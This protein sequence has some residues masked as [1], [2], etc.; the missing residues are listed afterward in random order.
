MGIAG[1]L[2]PVET[3]ASL[4]E[5]R[6]VDGHSGRTGALHALIP[7]VGGGSPIL[8]LPALLRATHLLGLALGAALDRLRESGSVPNP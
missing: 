2:W 1:G 4:P 7:A 6:S 5:S 3:R 8:A